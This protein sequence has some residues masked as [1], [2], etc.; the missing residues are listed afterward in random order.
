M[1]PWRRRIG[2]WAL[3]AVS[4]AEGFG[5]ARGPLWA[6]GRGQ[7]QEAN[8]PQLAD[9][10]EQAD[11]FSAPFELTVTENSRTLKFASNSGFKTE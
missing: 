5:G 2:A 9:A 1:P 8:L 11:L 6:K 3:R 7:E 4:G 10:T